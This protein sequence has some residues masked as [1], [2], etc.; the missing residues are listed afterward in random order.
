MTRC[1]LGIAGTDPTGGAGLQAD[2]KTM[3]ALGCYGSTVVTAILAQN[4]QAVYDMLPVPAEL[5]RAQLASVT[6]IFRID[7]VKIGMLGSCEI[8]H[9]VADRLKD[10]HQSSSNLPVVLDPVLQ[11]SSG[12]SLLPEQDI[13][14]LKDVLFPQ[15][16]LLTPNV[17]EAAIL[18]EEEQAETS[19]TLRQQ[20]ARLQKQVSWVLLK[21]GHFRGAESCDILAGPDGQIW[22]FPQRRLNTRH[23]RGTGCTLSAAL[24]CFL[25]IL[26][27]PEAVR[28]TQFYVWKALEQADDL[29]L[30]E[31]D[32]PLNHFWH[33]RPCPILSDGNHSEAA[34]HSAARMPSIPAERIP[35][36]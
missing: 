31:R 19:G 6:D 34:S 33:S 1:I 14:I 7:A 27:V 15:I 5:V 16:T 28:Q 2:L 36:A 18:L 35:P 26:P 22:E 3:T 8:I 13:Q 30:V 9:S 32:G 11:T 23:G 29:D 20:A 4:S 17:M 10:L 21:G 25:P 12:H 24:A